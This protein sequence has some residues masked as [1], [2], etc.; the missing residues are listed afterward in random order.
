M[1]ILSLFNISSAR[2]FLLLYDVMFA[3]LAALLGLRAAHSSSLSQHICSLELRHFILHKRCIF[4]FWCYIHVWTC[5]VEDHQTAVLVG[6]SKSP[7][8]SVHWQGYRSFINYMVASFFFLSLNLQPL[9]IIQE[10]HINLTTKSAF[11]LYQLLR[12][13]L[14]ASSLICLHALL[15]VHFTIFPPLNAWM[16]HLNLNTMKPLWALWRGT[17]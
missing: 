12:E 16:V 4:P 3:A 13:H 8:L 1:M 9:Q 7:H 5:N 11:C 2:P 17:F 10:T 15:S 14:R 6:L